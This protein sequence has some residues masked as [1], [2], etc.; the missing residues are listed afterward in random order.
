MKNLI[1]FVIIL[2]AGLL[3]LILMIFTALFEGVGNFSSNPSPSVLPPIRF[4]PT[5]VRAS[6]KYQIPW[7]FLATINK[8]ETNYNEGDMVSSAGALG[9][10]QFMYTTYEKYGQN[11]THN[12]NEPKIGTPYDFVDAVFASAKFLHDMGMPKN[13]NLIEIAKF[14]G[15]YNAGLGNWDNIS[16]QTVNYREMAVQYSQEIKISVKIPMEDIDYWDSL[17]LKTINLIAEGKKTVYGIG[18]SNISINSPKLK[19]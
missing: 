9:P 4:I 8:I 3:F 19:M 16:Q 15:A 7:W 17:P 5:Y 11:V 18:L 12:P 1:K 10:M 14:A 2:F 13:P 6:K